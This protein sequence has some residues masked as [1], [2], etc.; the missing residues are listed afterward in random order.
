MKY[1]RTCG[2]HSLV[3]VIGGTCEGNKKEYSCRNQFCDTF[4][5]SVF[6]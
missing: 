5:G 2:D 1:C 4:G 3:I 6:R